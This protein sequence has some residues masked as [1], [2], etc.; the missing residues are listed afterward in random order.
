MCIYL[1]GINGFIRSSIKKYFIEQGGQPIEIKFI[2]VNSSWIGLDD[3][4]EADAVIHAGA[5]SS[6][7]SDESDSLTPFAELMIL[8]LSYLHLNQQVKMR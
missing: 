7:Y 6:R 8:M 1:S 3:L 2:S 5:R 4:D